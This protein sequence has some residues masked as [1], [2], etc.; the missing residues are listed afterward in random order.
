MIM[1]T[2]FGFLSFSAIFALT[3]FQYFNTIRAFS[4]ASKYFSFVAWP[5]S[6]RSS[7]VM[8]MNEDAVISLINHKA[9][10]GIDDNNFL[11]A[12]KEYFSEAV[13]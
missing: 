8:T 2:V 3:L 6:I 12:Q 10:D 4:L 7:F 5:M 11:N 9:F 1:L 13:D